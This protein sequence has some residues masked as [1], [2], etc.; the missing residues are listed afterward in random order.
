MV[1]SEWRALLVCPV[2]HGELEEEGEDALVCTQCGRRYSIVDGIP[3]MVPD[4]EPAGE[5]PSGGSEG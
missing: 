5:T 1:N 3:D 2:D 4:E